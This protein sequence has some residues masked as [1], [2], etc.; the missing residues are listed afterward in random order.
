MTFYLKYRSQKIADLDLVEVR[1]SLSEIAKSGNMPHAFLFA[2]PKGTGKTSAARIIAKVVN[3]EH[4]TAGGEPCNKCDQCVSITKGTNLDVI[5][6]DAAS[7]RGIDDVRAIKD[8][9]KLAPAK[10]KKKV[11]IIDEAHMLTTE[12]SN[13]L[14]KTLEEPPEHCIFILATTNPEKLLPTIRSRTVNITFRKANE[15]EI[16]ASLGRIVK[17]EKI[18]ISDADLETIAQSAGGS[19][20]DAVKALE[21]F[22]L[23]GKIAVTTDFD[24]DKF[25]TLLAAKK[26]QDCLQEVAAYI[27]K[28]GQAGELGEIVLRYLRLGLLDKVGIAGVEISALSKIDLINLIILI[29]KA[30]AET[31]TAVI[32]E[33]VLG[34]QVNFN[35]FYSPLY[36]RLELLGTDTRRQTNIE[37]MTKIPAFYQNELQDKVALKYEE[38][39]HIAVT[40]LESLLESAFVMG[41]KFIKTSKQLFSPG[42]IGPFALQSIIVPGPPKKDIVVIDVSPRMPGSPGIA[43]TPYSGY[44]YKEPVSVG[45]RVAKEIKYGIKTKR[46]KEIV[47]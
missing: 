28:G 16:L 14:L 9:V 11:Y 25:I 47:S 38:A 13:A 5:E 20:R 8:A 23:E 1:Q 35:F 31:K 6:L 36:D 7:H 37:G 12:A 45:K 33:F 43:A 3:C 27:S 39:G 4:L 30:V 22:T 42:I 34:V 15:K 44:L 21:Q 41:E 10:A 32:E 2:G 46:I 18:K 19:F 29:S 40:V 24:V 17:A 26:T